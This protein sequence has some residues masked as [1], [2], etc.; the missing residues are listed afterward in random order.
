VS[1]AGPAGQVGPVLHRRGS[2]WRW[3]VICGA[4][5]LVAV[6]LALRFDLARPATRRQ[7]ELDREEVQVRV[8]ALCPITGRYLDLVAYA[9]SQPRISFDPIME[10]I[11][12]ALQLDLSIAGHAL[13]GHATSSGTIHFDAVRGRMLLDRVQITELA[14]GGLAGDLAA[15]LQLPLRQAL[16]TR[17]DALELYQDPVDRAHDSQD[18][19]WTIRHI[20]VRAGRMIVVLGR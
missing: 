17:L 3:I 7:V 13:Q 2:G 20:A 9:F 14:I 6:G 5:A 15:H 11:V 16:I 10:R 8:A 1:D 12:V 18:V 4:G 19:P